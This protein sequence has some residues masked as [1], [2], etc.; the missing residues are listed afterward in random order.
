MYFRPAP[1]PM[2]NQA[3]AHLGSI[4]PK[5][6]PL[7]RPEDPSSGSLQRKS[8]SAQDD[9]DSLETTAFHPAVGQQVDSEQR[10]GPWAPRNGGRH[11][12]HCGS[13][14]PRAGVAA[15]VEEFPR[16][17]GRR[18]C[19]HRFA[20]ARNLKAHGGEAVRASSPA[21]RSRP[22]ASLW[23]EWAASPNGGKE[24]RI[25]RAGDSRWP[26]VRGCL[27]QFVEVV[28]RRSGHAETWRFQVVTIV[29]AR[30][31]SLSNGK[32]GSPCT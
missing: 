20:S 12:E 19:T 10:D 31:E 22:G 9:D 11:C 21:S 6:N 5:R 27:E 15:S 1:F 7:G 2:R 3:M 23:N 26:V 18:R 13:F 14:L 29:A 24:P 25:P 16:L 17:L 32:Q 28:A 8:S 30:F 4:R